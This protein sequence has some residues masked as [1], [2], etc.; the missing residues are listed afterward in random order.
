MNETV[1]IS[2][3]GAAGLQEVPCVTYGTGDGPIIKDT[4]FELT[5]AMIPVP[6]GFRLLLAVPQV[7]EAYESGIIKTAQAQQQEEISTVIMQVVDMGPDA[8]SDEARFPSGPY[9][10]VGDHVLVRAYAGTRFKIHNK[11]LFRIVNDDNIEGVVA[12]PTGY[13]RI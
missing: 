2:G 6:T 9:C 1:A 3:I 12:D 5:D 7:E 10:K 11:E 8:Y 4:P 13:S